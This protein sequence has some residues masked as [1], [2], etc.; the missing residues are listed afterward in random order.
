M[1]RRDFAFSVIA[2]ALAP[3]AFAQS[4]VVKLVLP[5]AAGSGVDAITRAVGPALSKH[6]HADGSVTGVISEAELRTYVKR[7]LRVVG[8]ISA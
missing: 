8:A 7:T 4:G 1:N 2:A 3:A 6:H 5:N